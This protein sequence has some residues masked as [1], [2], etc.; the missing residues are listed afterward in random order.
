[1]TAQPV[2]P[3]PPALR[4][5]G[6]GVAGLL[7]L[8][9][10]ASLP[11]VPIL[12]VLLAMLAP[13]PLVHLVALGRP[14]FNGWGWVAVALAGAL[15]VTR[16]PWLAAFFAAYLLIAAWPAISV[17][18]WLRR[19]WSAG[20]WTAI[21][22][23]GALFVV[24]ALLVAA[25]Y[26][27]QAADGL[28]A[29]LERLTNNSKELLAGL[30]GPGQGADELLAQMVRTVAYLAPALAASYVM[31]VAFWLRPRLPLLGLA[32]GDE[33]FSSYA[34]EEWLPV[35]FALGGLGWVFLPEP[36]KWLAANLLV[37]VL[38]LYFM[39][40][41]A[42]IHFYLGPRLATNRWVR[43]AVAL[44]AIQMPLAFVVAVLGLADSFFRLRRDRVVDEGSD[45]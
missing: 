24:S 20:R 40:G 25:F 41:L 42:I 29:L 21:V 2:A 35:G 16:A 38:G 45:A 3:Q 36:G 18:A 9:A 4:N 7:S 6:P 32:R 22:T 39:H 34:S 14:S 11:W 27:G 44:L 31:S 19:R 1:M 43:L 37:T 23:M 10:V 15:V 26:P 13:L 17:E 8:A 30:S 28:V 33:P 12:G 5:I